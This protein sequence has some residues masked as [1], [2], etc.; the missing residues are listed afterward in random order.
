MRSD[1]HRIVIEKFDDVQR[2][3]TAKDQS[4][5]H[6]K[7]SK[8]EYEIFIGY[9]DM[10]GQSQFGTPS[11]D[12]KLTNTP[13]FKTVEKVLKVHTNQNETESKMSSSNKKYEI[14]R[15]NTYNF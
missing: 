13:Q 10:K 14:K 5:I 8:N 1:T 9:Q 11:I 7:A 12:K 6:S 15:K 3:F 4:I 2:S